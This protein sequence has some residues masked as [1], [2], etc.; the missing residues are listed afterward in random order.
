MAKVERDHSEAN[1]MES[2][3]RSE[4]TP[5]PVLPRTLSL[6]AICLVLIASN[7]QAFEDADADGIPDSFDPCPWS[8]GDEGCSGDFEVAP[9]A[10]M[11]PAQAASV[12]T[13]SAVSKEPVLLYDVDFGPPDI[14]GLPPLLDVG[15]APRRFAT[16]TLGGLPGIV[17]PSHGFDQH[18]LLDRFGGGPFDQLIFDVAENVFGGRGFPEQY[19]FYTIEVQLV[20]ESVGNKFV[21]HADAPTANNVAFMPDGRVL[22]TALGIGG[23]VAEIG[24]FVPGQAVDLMIQVEIQEQQWII[25]MDGVTVFTGPINTHANDGIPMRHARL[26]LVRSGDQGAEVHADNFRVYG[27]EIAPPPPISCLER[28]SALNAENQALT[29]ELTL[30][31]EQLG[32]IPDED[33]DGEADPTDRCPDTREGAAID[34]AGCSVKQFCANVTSDSRRKGSKHGKLHCDWADWRNDETFVRHPKDCTNKPKGRSKGA[35]KPMSCRAR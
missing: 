34:D 11:F 14:E 5:L 24:R 35:K 21:V 29:Q 16:S 7:A 33:G 23:Y 26:A 17:G 4:T 18:L 13:G 25:V 3:F 27:S 1:Q 12:E 19:P 10:A 31:E 28:L 9:R 2:T 6:I 20:L 32:V 15:P 30:C 22:A 8:V